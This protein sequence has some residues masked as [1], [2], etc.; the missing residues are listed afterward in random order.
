MEEIGNKVQSHVGTR[1]STQ[2][3]SHAQKF[4]KKVHI[5][6]VSSELSRLKGGTPNDPE[7]SV[8]LKIG[9]NEENK[10]VNSDSES[11]IKI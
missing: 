8:N 3:R 11:E 9:K 1:S 2:S 6:K 10:D 5:D 4:F 7:I